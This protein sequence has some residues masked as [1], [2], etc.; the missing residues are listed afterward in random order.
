MNRY[1]DLIMNR[2][3]EDKM[4]DGEHG[5]LPSTQPPSVAKSTGRGK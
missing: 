1:T 2:Y 4:S 3:T 5:Y